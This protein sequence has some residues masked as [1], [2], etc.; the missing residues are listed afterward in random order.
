MK[1]AS[2]PDYPIHPL[3]ADRWSP[4]A[5]DDRPV[6]TDKLNTLFEAARWA[7]SSFNAQPW[8]FVVAQRSQTE[9]FERLASLLNTG[10]RSWAEQAPVLIAAIARLD[11]P[12]KGRHNRHAWHDLGLAIGNLS[13]QATALDLYLHQM[14][15]FNADTA[16]EQLGIPDGHAAATMIALGYLGDPATLSD[17]LRAREEAPRSRKTIDEFVFQGRWNAK[18]D[19]Q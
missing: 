19:A 12:H 4:R 13:V 11:F 9:D 18:R 14:A 6:E 16:A 1:T 15:G 10:N 8:Y 3:L 7:A 17:T 5:F 2:V